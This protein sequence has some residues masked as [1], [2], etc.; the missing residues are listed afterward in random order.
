V[1]AERARG[2]TVFLCSHVLSDVQELCDRVVVIHQGVVARDGTI[3][4]LLDSEPCSF[5]LC[6]ERVSDELA[7]RIEAAATLVRRAGSTLTA[8]L[9]GKQLG[10]EF[11]A[12]VHAEGGQVLSLIPERETL[13]T[14][15]VRATGHVGADGSIV[16]EREDVT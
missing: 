3:H 4:D 14:W 12:A 11:A 5:E 10:P 6:A 15:F 2:K 1:L 16:A 8:H 9:P 7:S 13:E